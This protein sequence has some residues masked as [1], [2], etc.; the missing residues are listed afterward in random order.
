M[1][2]IVD[3]RARLG[4]T[5][6]ALPWPW[7]IPPLAAFAVHGRDVAFGF[8]SLDD[9]TLIV[10]DQ[11]FLASPGAPFAAFGR[12]YFHV[13]DAGHAYY[14][15]IVTASYALDARWSGASP[16]GYHATNVVLHAVAALLVFA[17]ARRIRIREGVAIC[18]ALVFAV[19]PAVVEAV[20]WIPGRNDLLLAVFALAAL[21]FYARG[22]LLAHLACFALALF[23]KE[24][25][26][27]VPPVCVL[28]AWLVA[29]GDASPAGEL[30]ASMPRSASRRWMFVIGWALVTIA[31]A[32]A[33]AR[34]RDTAGFASAVDPRVALGHAAVLVTG[35]GKLVLPVNLSV[36]ATTQDAPP[37]AGVA[38]AAALALFVWRAPRVRPRVAL[39]GALLFALALAPAL[40]APGSLALESRLYLPLVGV[41]LVVAAIVDALAIERRV[42][43]A[44]AASTAMALAAL[45]F[46]YAEAFRD[47]RAFANAAVLGSPRSSLAHFTLGQS[48]QLRGDLDR[49]AREYALALLFDPR[50]PIVHNNLAVIYMRRAEWARAEDELHQE[51]DVNPGYETAEKNLA[52]VGRHRAERPHDAE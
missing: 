37:W 40:F 31:F 35:L 51:L 26:L 13:I 47:P 52:I 11:P 50:E 41:L 10:D 42:I 4:A 36:L 46:G 38:G 20:A 5:L 45:S 24:T 8:T 17:L 29:R 15:P 6:R 49:A 34:V 48:Q 16:F 22:A 7:F 25:A 2:T 28:Y 1:P 14:R 9:L 27:A 3:L 33:R 32:C 21:L 18:A 12:A 23:T 43:V 19:H 39:F 30:R 44:C